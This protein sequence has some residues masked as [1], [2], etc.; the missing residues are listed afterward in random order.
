M[1]EISIVNFFFNTGRENWTP[2]NGFPHYLHRTVDTYFERF[3]HLAQLDNQI[4]VY[5]SPE[6]VDRILELR[7]DKLEKTIVIPFDYHNSFNEER[8]KIAEIQTSDEFQKKINPNQKLNPEYWNPDYILMMALKSYFLN[9]AIEN[10]LVTNDTA[11]YI[12]FGYCRT[13]DKIPESKKWE[14]DFDQ[15]KI[16][17]F[18]YKDFPMEKSIEEVIFNNEV[19]IL[20]AKVIASTKLWPELYKLVWGNLRL[21]QQHNLV[22]DD[23]TLW[24]MSYLMKPELFEIHKIPDHQLGL[25]A[26]V[27]FNQ[28]NDTVK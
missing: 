1:S 3:G 20:G 24:L 22:D 25:D 8:L 9:H 19:Y 15:N 23:Q 26:F 14:Y 5:T 13:A 17:L 16:H 28:Y 4:I 2:E 7:K 21:L 6:F 12:D 18:G 10:N 11:A 27:L